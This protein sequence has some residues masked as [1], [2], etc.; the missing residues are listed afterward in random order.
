MPAQA[1]VRSSR[2]CLLAGLT[3][4]FGGAWLARRC[5]VRLRTNR[6]RAQQLAADLH[7]GVA[8][9]LVAL[10]SSMDPSDP[11]QR[12]VC[13]ALLDCLLD[14]QMAFDGIDGRASASVADQLGSLRY[15]VQ[16]ALDRLGMQLDWSVAG[17]AVAPLG[18]DAGE[19][20]KIAQ[21]ALSNVLR[22][23]QAARVQ[24]RWG[25]NPD[26]QLVLE[27]LDD[28]V[29]FGF[30]AATMSATPS[31]GLRGMHERARSL[32]AQLWIEPVAP[33]GTRVRLVLSAE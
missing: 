17:E 6:Q 21:E 32:D 9:G 15:R 10:A 5:V 30:G 31:R 3:V 26:G 12:R 13:V 19:V 4:V 7:D 23:S 20:C 29:G 33:H 18:I 25:R 11:A 22:H 14:L 2:F 1:M 24:L 8:S 27:V 16:P 28:G